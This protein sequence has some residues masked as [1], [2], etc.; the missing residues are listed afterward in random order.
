MKPRS[1]WSRSTSTRTSGACACVFARVYPILSPTLSKHSQSRACWGFPTILRPF[2]LCFT[3]PSPY[4]PSC[5]LSLAPLSRVC[6]RAPNYFPPCTPP[7]T[8]HLPAPGRARASLISTRAPP[9]RNSPLLPSTPLP[10]SFLHA[11]AVTPTL[12][13]LQ[14]DRAIVGHLYGFPLS[15]MRS[16]SGK[17]ACVPCLICARAY[18]C[19]YVCSCLVPE[20]GLVGFVGGYVHVCVSLYDFSAFLSLS[21][22]S[23]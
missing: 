10:L 18:A 12:S 7:K 8:P 13:L 16:A 14:H 11:P 21:L 3:H 20:C 19:V 17:R 2:W 9:S 4:T 22:P 6:A 15:G 5:I 1:R 23:G